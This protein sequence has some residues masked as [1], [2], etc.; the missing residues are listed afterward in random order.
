MYH[1]QGETENFSTLDYQLNAETFFEFYNNIYNSLHT[2]IIITLVFTYHILE[3]SISLGIY[4]GFL[5]M[6]PGKAEI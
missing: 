4:P 1:L 3:T 6:F 5:I 2:N